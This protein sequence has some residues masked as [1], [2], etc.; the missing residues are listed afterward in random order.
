MNKTILSA[1]AVDNFP[2]NQVNGQN[3][4]FATTNGSIA[5]MRPRGRRDSNGNY[6]TDFFYVEATGKTAEQLGQVK[7]G[8]KFFAEGYFYNDSFTDREGAKRTVTRF[9]ID[10]VERETADVKKAYAQQNQQ[11]VNNQNAGSMAPQQPMN[12]P[13]SP[14]ANTPVPQAGAAPQQAAPQQT[15]PQG[16]FNTPA[17]MPAGQGMPSAMPDFGA[18]DGMPNFADTPFA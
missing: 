13:A 1:R 4:S 7:K 16:N 8:D 17:G 18:L 5:V 12:Q 15:I 14:V 9:R 2:I 10:R 11:P 6:P 3:G